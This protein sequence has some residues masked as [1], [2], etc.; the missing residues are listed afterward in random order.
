MV[1]NPPAVW[2]TWIRSL[3]WEDPLEEGMATHSNIL[4][5]KI[6]IDRGAWLAIVHGVTKSQMTERLS[7]HYQ[8][9]AFQFLQHLNDS[10]F[11]LFILM[12][13][14][15]CV[16][17]LISQARSLLVSKIST[18]GFS[19]FLYYLFIKK[20]LPFFFLFFCLPCAYF[21]SLPEFPSAE[22]QIIILDIFL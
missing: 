14:I 8:F 11:S 17:F 7:T 2:E 1:K 22:D 16:L 5:W 15:F 9:I 10:L 21:S 20:I 3:G 18:F 19:D 12:T 4:V 13:R 6:P